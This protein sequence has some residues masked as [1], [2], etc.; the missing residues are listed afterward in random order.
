MMPAEPQEHP[1]EYSNRD[2]LVRLDTK[3]DNLAERVQEIRGEVKELSFRVDRLESERDRAAGGFSLARWIWGAVVA[4]P[5]GL[6]IGWFT[7]ERGGP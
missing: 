7:N 5:F 6:I 2:L 4:F 1:K 3:F